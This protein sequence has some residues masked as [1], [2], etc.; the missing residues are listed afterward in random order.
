MPRILRVVAEARSQSGVGAARAA[1]H[2][3][4]L[5]GAAHGVGLALEFEGGPHVAEG[6]DRA[7]AA[8]RRPVGPPALGRQG[9]AGGVDGVL[10][11]EVVQADS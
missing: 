5:G 8:D 6:T 11:G 10:D 1:G 2:H 9:L 4:E 3:D 7:G